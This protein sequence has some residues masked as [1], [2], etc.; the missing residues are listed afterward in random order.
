MTTSHM[1]TPGGLIVWLRS[2]PDALLAE[3]LA[4]RVKAEAFALSASADI[5]SIAYGVKS[6]DEVEVHDRRVAE[7]GGALVVEC[8]EDAAVLGQYAKDGVLTP[9]VS[10]AFEFLREH[11]EDHLLDGAL[12]SALGEAAISGCTPEFVQDALKVLG[13]K[14]AEYLEQV[15]AA[16]PAFEAIALRRVVEGLQVDDIV[17]LVRRVRPELRGF[18]PTPE[19]SAPGMLALGDGSELSHEEVL[20]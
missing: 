5:V 4:P 1:P 13:A 6:A 9:R 12:A 2:A 7:R 17:A 10:E 18:G 15:E 19:P 11:A 16:A 3:A 14:R 8:D 20:S